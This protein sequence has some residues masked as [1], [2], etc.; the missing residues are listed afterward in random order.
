MPTGCRICKQNCWRIVNR[1]YV[2]TRQR[3]RMSETSPVTGTRRSVIFLHFCVCVFFVLFFICFSFLRRRDEWRFSAVVMRDRFEK[4]R[5]VLD[6][7]KAQALL[8]QGQLEFKEKQH[9]FPLQCKQTCSQQIAVLFWHNR[10]IHICTWD[11]MLFYLLL[12]IKKKV[13]DSPGGT[14]YGRDPPIPDFV[15]SF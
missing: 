11:E 13:P 10:S 14:A 15:S 8:A 2:C 7:V 9:P 4:N 1:C 5:N 6:L 12:N 3:S